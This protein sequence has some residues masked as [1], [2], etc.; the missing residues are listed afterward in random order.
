LN[1][2][3][4]ALAIASALIVGL[5]GCSTRNVDIEISGATAVPGAKGLYRM[6][7]MSTLIYF[8][9][10]ANAD[11]EYDAYF[12]FHCAYDKNS[13]KW[14]MITDPGVPADYQQNQKES[15]MNQQQERDK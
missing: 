9:S 13:D 15:E 12:A 6:C 11:D 4:S 5:A 1:K 7:D 2:K 3:F 14:Y 10:I 8:T